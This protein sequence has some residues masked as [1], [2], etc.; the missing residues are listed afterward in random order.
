MGTEP[1]FP[2]PVE[3]EI[4]LGR[5]HGPLNSSHFLLSRPLT[6]LRLSLRQPTEGAVLRP[7]G[8]P[9]DFQCGC[10]GEAARTAPNTFSGERLLPR[11]PEGL[12]YSPLP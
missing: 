12:E 4:P 6:A 10:H 2:Q 5:L 7:S 9:P 1:I 11:L 3:R 8:K